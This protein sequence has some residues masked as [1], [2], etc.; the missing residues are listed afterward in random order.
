MW[1]V[2]E[3]VLVSHDQ[4]DWWPLP[5]TPTWVSGSSSQCSLPALHDWHIREPCIK[6]LLEDQRNLIADTATRWE[7]Q[8]CK[9]KIFSYSS[10][11]FQSS[12]GAD[13]SDGISLS[14]EA[15]L[16]RSERRVTWKV[17]FKSYFIHSFLLSY[18]SGYSDD[19]PHSSHPPPHP[20]HHAHCHTL[21]LL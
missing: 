7:M 15:P 4:W 20:H 3:E 1:Q 2:V 12:T 21:R 11:N 19:S 5:D 17:A 6:L 13:R 8:I 16:C 9:M 10:R 18:V 14:S